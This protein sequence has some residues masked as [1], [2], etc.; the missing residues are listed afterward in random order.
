ML[1]DDGPLRHI[2]A[3]ERAP[4]ARAVIKDALPGLPGGPLIEARRRKTS[5]IAQIYWRVGLWGLV[6]IYRVIYEMGGWLS[7]GHF[8]S[9]YEAALCFA[10]PEAILP[11]APAAKRCRTSPIGVVRVS[12]LF[13]TGLFNTRYFDYATPASLRFEDYNASRPAGCTGLMIL[14]RAPL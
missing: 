9:R 12:H 6:A 13:F 7:R 11:D 5:V 8:I 2:C 14:M 10:V 1:A 4:E 3:A